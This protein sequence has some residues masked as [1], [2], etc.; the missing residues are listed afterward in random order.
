MCDFMSTLKMI[1]HV[2]KILK[3]TNQKN[4]PESQKFAW[5]IS[6]EEFIIVKPL[7]CGSQ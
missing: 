7:F 5:R 4:L 1:L 6:V 2:E 3:I